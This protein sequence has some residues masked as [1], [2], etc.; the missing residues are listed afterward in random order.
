MPPESHPSVSVVV[1]SHTPSRFLELAMRSV[2]E[3]DV[4]AD[5]VE[6][7]LVKNYEDP[8][9]ERTAAELGFESVFCPDR[10]GGGKAR[11]ALR[12]CRGRLVTFLDYDDLYEPNRLGT[13]IAAFDADPTLGFYHNASVCIDE[14][15][16]EL[17]WPGSGWFRLVRGPRG[18]IYVRD[19]AKR[20]TDPRLGLSRADFNASSM[21][22]RRDLIDPFWAYLERV[23]VS[24]DS[25]LFYAAWA[26]P[27]SLL[28]DP[29]PLTRYRVHP[30][31]VSSPSATVPAGL[32]GGPSEFARRRES[33]LTACLDMVV[34]AHRS[35]AARDLRFLSL[36]DEAVRS[37]R[38]GT[39][40]RRA[41]WSYG[42]EVAVLL[43]RDL[44]RTTVTAAI[45]WEL[46]GFLASGLFSPRLSRRLDRL[47][48]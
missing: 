26:S 33:D 1:V 3:Q 17:P 5:T 12:R 7:I 32:A 14:S 4:P 24:L 34:D 13:L 30:S 16:R 48:M 18:R 43:G 37:I 39:L 2:A 47:G 22:V 15:G 40:R 19:S 38:A 8:A 36:R 31:N 6:R 9:T 27:R 21:A 45:A 42:R 35:E 20:R 10:S 23:D 29:T 11:E 46:L 41:A 28:I 44:L 25:F